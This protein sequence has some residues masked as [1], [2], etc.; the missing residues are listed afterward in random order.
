[1]VG[2]AQQ[3]LRL[4]LIGFRPSLS[5]DW[6]ANRVGAPTFL[7]PIAF[8]VAM[9]VPLWNSADYSVLS[10]GAAAAYAI[11]KHNI[12][13]TYDR[14]PTPHALRFP[15][16]LDQ[17]KADGGR[18]LGAIGSALVHVAAQRL[19]CYPDASFDQSCN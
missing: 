3:L 15:D 14:N 17:P 13:V 4:L 12:A 8:G 5:S 2:D 1:L 10:A 7:A 11:P 19:S 6:S 16:P 18:T 9:T